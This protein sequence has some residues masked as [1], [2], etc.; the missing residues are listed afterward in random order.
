MGIW[1]RGYFASDTIIL[2]RD[3]TYPAQQGFRYNHV[4]CDVAS[5]RGYVY[6][7]WHQE[8]VPSNTRF[9]DGTMWGHSPT[10][11]LPLLWN[12]QYLSP[13]LRF[14]GFWYSHSAASYAP[15]SRKSVQAW[16][17]NHNL[18]VPVW[19]FLLLAIPPLR[20]WQR[21]RRNRGRGFPVE[22]STAP[23]AGAGDIG[24]NGIHGAGR[25]SD[26]RRWSSRWMYSRG[27]GGLSKIP[28]AVGIRRHQWVLRRGAESAGC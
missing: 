11:Y 24:V 1:V 13:N 28:G 17:S 25:A 10:N 15:I 12:G 5:E 18:T 2:R 23:G 6:L 21:W 20:W 27:A 14:A 22:L 26:D 19:I 7:G 8:E 16:H 3:R 9:A 4:R